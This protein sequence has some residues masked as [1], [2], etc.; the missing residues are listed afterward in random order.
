MRFAANGPN[1]PD[2]LLV[3]RDEG[4]VV[5]FC[6]AGV[7]LAKA[8]LRDFLGL[9]QDVAD[10]L[11]IPTDNPAR[12][13]INAIK[14]VPSIPG[15]GSLVAADRVFGLIERDYMSRDIHRAIAAS[16]KPDGVP[17]LT[18][19]RVL[20]DLAKGPDGIVRLITTNFDLLF[21]ACDPTISVSQH[22]HLSDPLRSKDFQGIIHLH[23]SVTA[24]YTDAAGE[25]LIISSGEF[26]RAYLSDRWATDFIRT[27]LERFF[28]VFVGYSADDPP[29]QYLLEALNRSPGSFSGAYALQSGSYEDAEARWVQKG[30]KPI[31]YEAERQHSL[32]WESLD[33]W[34]ERARRP[35]E[36]HAAI[37]QKAMVGPERCEPYIRGQ[38]SHLASTLDGAKRIAQAVDALPAEWLCT[39]DP[40]V[41]F[42]QPGRTGGLMKPGQHFVPFAAYGLDSDPVPANFN[43]D[44]SIFQK[45]EIPSNVWNAFLLMR[46]DRQDLQ[47]NQV[48][49]LRGHWAVHAPGLSPRIA[50]LGRWLQRVAHQPTAIWWAASQHGLHPDIQRQIEYSMERSDSGSS[51][52]TR[53]AWRYLIRSW[54]T[55]Q[56]DDYSPDYFQL[57]AAIKLD[58]WSPEMA[59]EFAHV[60][61]PFIK[62]S[63]EYSS[64]PR[65]PDKLPEDLSDLMH[66][67]VK[68]PHHNEDVSVPDTLLPILAK[69]LRLN[70]ELGAALESELGAYGLHNL[71]PIESDEEE[72]DSSDRGYK[73]GINIPLF[74]YVKFVRR[75]LESDA[76]AA[77]LEAF[78]WRNSNG[79][80]AAHIKIW[81]CNDSR[82][83]SR[84]EIAS[85]LKAVSREEFWEGAHQRDLLLALKKRWK[86]MP[87]LTK[88]NIERRL[89]QG[90]KRW[91]RE[92]SKDYRERKA[93]AILGRI[94]YLHSRGCE[95]SFDLDA[96]TEQLRTDCPDWKP[97]WA[98]KAAFSMGMRTGW[99][100]T[101]KR[102]DDLQSKPLSEILDAAAK[103]SGRS[104]DEMFVERNPFAGL[105][106]VK[107]FLAFAALSVAAKAGK[108]PKGPWQTFLNSENS[109]RDRVRFIALIAGRLSRLP[110]EFLAELIRPVSD[111][112][113]RTYKTLLPSHRD[114]LDVLWTRIMALIK[115]PDASA[116][117]SIVRTNQEPDWATSALN[118]PVG[119]LAQVLMGDPAINGLKKA[120]ICFP[121]WWKARA[122]ELLSL[123]G[124]HRRYALA[125]FCH[126]LV[127]LFAIDPNWVVKA[128]LPVI[129]GEDSDSDAF[130]AGFFWGAKVPQRELYLRMKPALLRLAHKG[131]DTRRKHA[132]ILAGIILVG[133]GNRKDSA[134]VRV[135]SD[136]EMTAV[137]LD[138]DDDFRVQLLWHLENWTKQAES[139]W[140]EDAAILLKQVWPKQ[141]AA[142]TPRVSA[143][144]AELAF[145]QGDRFPLFIDYVLPLVVP[146]DQDYIRL[147]IERTDSD[148]LVETYPEQTLALLDAVL[149]DNA[150]QWPYGVSE[151]LDRI[152]KAE[153][154]LLTDSRLIRLNRV[155]AS[156]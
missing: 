103:L 124:N 53:K 74:E 146:I 54:R 26:G 48:S 39:F 109:K 107:P 28:V 30:V 97:E 64:S 110:D 88:R 132:E 71:E 62:A 36:W 31:V 127:W 33:L 95:F 47:E 17:D 50:H 99:V 72:A 8:G 12:Q 22:P 11:S 134:E 15:V 56:D 116:D 120:G 130:W 96:V 151:I 119:Y 37:L 70:L 73:Y 136:N 55:G 153:T 7:S 137:L 86:E 87:S 52:L 69:E 156:F 89:L 46:A 66:L 23:G 63:R 138:A 34:A 155:R 58:G 144:L 106:E 35:T 83:V 67:D 6:G 14:N 148:L 139:E 29:M 75:L 150:R 21:E 27:V 65:P 10:R 41:R 82:L 81:S 123:S 79:P 51:P 59:R 4:R 40:F 9:A 90:G 80:V 45:Y 113:L 38:I 145:A 19:H 76:Y 105:C 133:W 104:P 131:S 84:R 16:L 141:I 115:R 61:R 129:E 43:P 44:D 91:K 121:D 42:A 57:L 125:I 85:V 143:K 100:S 77:R 101:D 128:L 78:A 24:D 94:H 108:C 147:P 60:H 118:S 18:A 98:S 93:S 114:I 92:P 122:D 25:G 68:Y 32:L 140:G 135:I 126:N 49:S 1:F 117:T 112:M 13:L 5:F 154:Q 142:K 111:W 149:T 2:E 3:A 20:L 102:S 152:A